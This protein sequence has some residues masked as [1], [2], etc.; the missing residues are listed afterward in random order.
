LLSM[1]EDLVQEAISKR[2]PLHK[3]AEVF[4]VD[5]NE[6]AKIR[7]KILEIKTNTKLNKVSSIIFDFNKLVG[8][9]IENPI[10]GVA[11][12]VGVVGPILIKGD[13][14]N[15]ELYLPIATTEGAL[16]ASVNRGANAT[17]KSGG[18]KTKILKDYM[19]RAPVFKTQSL[20]M[21]LAVKEWIEKNFEELK[22]VAESTTRHGKLI[23]ATSFVIGNNL[24]VR[25]SFTTSDAMGMNMVTIASERMCRLIERET[26]AKLVSLSG[27]LCSDKKSSLVNVLLGRGKNV[28]A[29]CVIKSSVIKEVLKTTASEIVDVNIRKNM[30][31]SA[32]AG[33]F[34]QN[35]HFANIIAGAFIALG[36]DVAQTVE[37]S[38]GYV[39]AEQRGD[40]LYFSITLPNLEIGT[41]GG[42][43]ALDAQRELLELTGALKA[44]E[45]ER[46]KWLAEVIAAGVLCGELSLL[47]ALASNTLAESHIKLGRGLKTER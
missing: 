32:L 30:L 19:T 7:A 5:E 40:D 15:G 45:G 39:F 36:Q 29:E 37:S 8:K 31:G 26:G 1:R 6:A 43:T 2:I 41:V 9:N 38:Q 10:G 11:L 25:F 18:I 13:Y 28:V 24:F 14:A 17:F 23:D 35:A 33:S 16:V 46:A 27:N 21:S 42:G 44:K 20:E 3:I 22:K 34:S 12:P 47:A 4:G